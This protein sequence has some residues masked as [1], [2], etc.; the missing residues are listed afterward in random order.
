VPAIA[1]SRRFENS[2]ISLGYDQ[3]LQRPG[4]NQLNPFVDRSN[5]IFE[6]TGNPDLRPTKGNQLR[7]GY[8]RNKK[9]NLNVSLKY[10]WIRGLIFQVSDYDAATNITRTRFE[11]TGS[12]KAL[13][14]NLNFSY[15]I[16]EAWNFSLNG[17]LAHGWADGLSNGKPIK[18]RGFMYNGNLSTS[19]RMDKGWRISGNAYL[20]GGDL[21]VQQNSNAFVGT[22]VSV[23][24]DIIKDKLSFSSF[25]NNPLNR[26]RVNI[27]RSFGPNFNQINN[28]QQNF[29]TMGASLSYQ[30]GRLKES[31]KKNQRGIKNDDIS[32]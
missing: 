7:I 28:S 23:N 15:P 11:N 29:R 17:S 32:N 12:A 27:T 21:T 31:I 2:S 5:P 24:K 10:S 14:G 25:I 13:G 6:K 16:T 1:L 9:S 30:F 26:Y 20:N 8:D 19:L 4:I 18:N 3:R 22:S